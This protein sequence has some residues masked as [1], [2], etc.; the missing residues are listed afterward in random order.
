MIYQDFF[1]DDYFGTK[2]YG[3]RL[4]W[5][6]LIAAAADDQGRILDNTSLIRAK[7]FMYDNTKN[8]DVDRWL[9][10]LNADNKIVRYL[11]DGKPL[12]QIIKWWDYQTPAWASHSKYPPPD[13]WTDR[14]RCHVTSASQGGEIETINWK[15]KGGF[16]SE[17][18]TELRSEQGSSLSSGID[19]IK[20]SKDNGDSNAAINNHSFFQKVWEQE[21]GKMIAGFTKFY[22]MCDMFVEKGVTPDMY[23]VAIQEQSKSDYPVKNPTSVETWALGLLKADKQNSTNNQEYI[24]P[25]DEVIRL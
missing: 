13:G 14:V 2:E 5:I 18:P 3:M 12:I 24:G 17:L 4:L 9:T 25:D 15:R 7:V 16:Y 22:K 11:R 1:E 23:R 10:I 6:G 21:T 19:D 20:L 8:D